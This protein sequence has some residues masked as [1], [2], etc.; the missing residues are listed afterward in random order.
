MDALVEKV[1]DALHKEEWYFWFCNSF[2]KPKLYLD[3]YRQLSRP[4][5]RHGWI[6]DK[7]YQRLG[8]PWEHMN[9]IKLVDVPFPDEV[10]DEA[11]RGFTASISVALWDKA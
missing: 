11:L 4:T 3:S 10:K 1:T 6:I 9:A 7:Q 5:K 8:R 2:S